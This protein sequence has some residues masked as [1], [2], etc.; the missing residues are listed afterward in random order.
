MTT[1]TT[2]RYRAGTA[3]ARSAAIV[4]VSASLANALVALAAVAL[5]AEAT[6]GLQPMAYIAFT[7]IAAIAGAVGWH[8]INRYTGRPARVMR[9][10]VPAF[11][12]VSFVPDILV[13]ATMGWLAAAALMLMHVVTITIAVLTYRRY[14]PLRA[15]TAGGA[16]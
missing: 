9:W 15:D 14:L 10:L 7:V 3:I 12:V 5:G 1:I 6:G 16:D 11:L 8:L 2:T 13:G 4:A